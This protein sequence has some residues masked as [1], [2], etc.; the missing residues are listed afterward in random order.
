MSLKEAVLEE[1]KRF[2]EFYLWLE[3]SMPKAFFAEVSPEW[4][5]LIVHALMGFKSQDYFSQ[6]HLKNGGIALAIDSPM[7]D[8]KILDKYSFFSIKNYTTYISKLPLPESDRKIYLRIATIHF[9][10]PIEESKTSLSEEKRKELLL[11]LEKYNKLIDRKTG[12]AILEKMDLHYLRLLPFERQVEALSLYYRAQTRDL[13]QYEVHFEEEWKEKGIPSL[14]ILLAWKN[15]PRLNFLY[16]LARLVFD[17]NLVMHRINAA[18]IDSYTPEGVLMLSFTL[19]GSQDEAA[20]KATKMVDFLRELAT[21]KFFG[22]LDIFTETFVDTKILSGSEINL[23]R[24]LRYFIQQILVQ[25]DPNLYNLKNIDEALTRHPELI[26]KLV[27]AFNAKFHPEDNNLKKYEK[28]K[29]EYMQLVTAID[30]GNEYEDVARKNILFQAMHFVAF[31]LKTNFFRNN[32]SALS[33][34]LDPKILDMAPYDRKKVF[35]ELPFAI[36]FIKGMHFFGFHIRFKDLSRG[37]L[38]TV[39]PADKDRMQSE[40]KIAFQECYNLALTQNKKNKDIPEG[41]AKGIIFLKPFE[42]LE[43]EAEI[44]KLDLIDSGWKPEEVEEK[45]E[46]FQASEKMEYLYESQRAFI[47]NFLSL[48]NCEPDGTLRAKGIV[49]YWKKPEYIYLGPDENMHDVMIE[50]IAKESVSVNYRPGNAFISGKP[51]LGINHKAYGVTSLGVTVYMHEVLNFLGINPEKEIFTVKMTGGPDGDVAGN[52]IA[53][54]Y[55]YYKKTAKIVA[56]TDVSGTINDPNGL[57]LE[58]CYR[59]FQEGKSIRHYPPEKLS[60]GGFLLDR[61]TKKEINPYTFHTL[62]WGKK[63]GKLIQEWLI[64]NEMNSLFRFNVHQTHATLFIPCGGRPRTLSDTN[65]KEFL[66][67]TSKPT[68]AAI[69]EGANL[70]LTPW[71]RKSLEEKGVLIVKDSSANKGGVI[72]SSFEILCGLTLSDEEFLHNKDSLVEEIL[73]RVKACCYN[74]AQLLLDSHKQTKKPLTEI[75]EDISEKINHY[76]DQ[77][78]AYLDTIQLSPNTKDPFVNMFL[79]YAPKTLRKKF[80]KEL[81]SKIP[82]NHKKAIIATSIAASLVY[83]RGLDWSPTIID[84]LPILIK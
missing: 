65:Y 75:S 9:D 19:H 33:F 67:A 31:T 49:D 37:G 30:T 69:I 24:S 70:Y 80:E 58:V 62:L 42:R 84:I 8:V 39:F 36:F 34:R 35:P 18:Y 47:S 22:S 29:D 27:D 68:A 81:L 82:D 28:I 54:F 14:H 15:T 20:W 6:I 53:N 38:R 2:E 77:L 1:S 61:E 55:K 32:K 41:G 60:E 73:E 5:T 57:D 45:I 26:R 48:I 21:L 74:E 79:T 63:N 76:T 40:I 4:I 51:K 13:C 43:H 66:D 7:A 25:L 16:R 59:L 44:L 17:H 3:K 71:A 50:W 10:S 52:Q 83:S 12:L 56:L 46:Q 72:T 64:G 78:I 11:A 23:L